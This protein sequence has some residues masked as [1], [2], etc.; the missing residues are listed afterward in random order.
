MVS[1]LI[2]NKWQGDKLITPN[3]VS[4]YKRVNTHGAKARVLGLAYATKLNGA[5]FATD[6]DAQLVAVQSNKVW[7]TVVSVPDSQA[8]EAN[9]YYDFEN[10]EYFEKG[11]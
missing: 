4:L 7:Y 2:V 8:R 11:E 3:M 5:D 9:N 1:Y 10:C 6:K